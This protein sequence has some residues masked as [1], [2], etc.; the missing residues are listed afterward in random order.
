ML[1]NFSIVN[2]RPLTPDA[3]L[4]VQHRSGA[5]QPHGERRCP[6][7]PARG[8]A[9]PAAATTRSTPPLTM[10]RQPSK[11]GCSTES[12]GSPS[13]GRMCSRGP[14]TSIRPGATSSS[15]PGALELPGQ[16]AQVLGGRL[17]GRGDGDGVGLD[18]GGHGQDVVE[19]ADG[20]ARLVGDAGTVGRR[21]ARGDDVQTR[22]AA[23]ARRLPDQLEDGAT[24][25]D[26]DDALGAAAQAPQPAQPRAGRVA[27]EHGD[28]R[29]RRGMA[30]T[31]SARLRSRFAA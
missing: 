31:T 24:A 15:M 17:A 13:N 14:A 25:T 27:T 3:L 29:S 30:T 12:S 6:A 2:E 8:A 10:R 1:R 21:D 20:H 18:P 28:R 7:G 4:P 23:P 26:D 16:L 5:G 9:A 19:A 11:R 22:V